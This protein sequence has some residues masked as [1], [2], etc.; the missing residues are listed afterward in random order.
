MSVGFYIFVS[1]FT[2][3][4]LGFMFPALRTL[5]SPKRIMGRGEKSAPKN[6]SGAF[7]MITRGRTGRIRQRKPSM[8]QAT[9]TATPKPSVK[10]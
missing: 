10:L 1:L 5:I 9:A 7:R 4:Q 8:E 3:L 2:L 6:L